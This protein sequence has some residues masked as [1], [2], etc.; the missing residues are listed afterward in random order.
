MKQISYVLQYGQPCRVILSE[1]KLPPG[2]PS[3]LQTEKDLETAMVI[4][5]GEAVTVTA[6]A[7][8]ISTAW[9]HTRNARKEKSPAHQPGEYEQ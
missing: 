7:Q 9:Q 4:I 3:K 8:A 5:A 6:A 2:L 1:M